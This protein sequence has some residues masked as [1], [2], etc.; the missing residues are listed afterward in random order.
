MR[1]VRLVEAHR[2]ELEELADP[3]PAAGEVVVRVSGCGICG[4]DL[5]A[6]KVGL[7]T[8]IVPGHELAGVVESAGDGVTGWTAGDVAVIDPKTPCG[9]CDDCRAGARYRC[10][11][12]LTAGIGFG[13]DGGLAELVAAPAALLH[14]VPA[15]IRAED[16]CLVEPLS[17]AIHGVE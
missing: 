7:F 16:A 13:R 11:M 9:A 17:V 3:Q 6:Y 2:L 15:A 8:G 5:S 4:S 14:R 10:A 1:A 12:S